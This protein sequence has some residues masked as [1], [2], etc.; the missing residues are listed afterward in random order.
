M[1]SRFIH[2]IRHS[3]FFNP[4]SYLY[5]PTELPTTADI[6]AYSTTVYKHQSAV[7][8]RINS[9]SSYNNNAN[10]AVKASSTAA[11]TGTNNESSIINQYL[12]NNTKQIRSYS[13][14]AGNPSN[15]TNMNQFSGLLHSPI[16][17]ASPISTVESLVQLYNPKSTIPIKINS[18]SSYSTVC[19]AAAAISSRSTRQQLSHSNNDLFRAS[20]YNPEY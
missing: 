9:N 11:G 16:A 8:N 5:I 10:I 15:S 6:A 20:W 19:D 2:T 7:L 14:S 12:Y 3:Q 17:I 1:F 13:S 18:N 4:G